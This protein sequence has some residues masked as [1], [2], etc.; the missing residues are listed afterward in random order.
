[1]GATVVGKEIYDEW[2]KINVEIHNKLEELKNLDKEKK[3]L[4]KKIETEG[5][6]DFYV[7]KMNESI[8]KYEILLEEVSELKEKSKK[9]KEKIN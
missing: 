2:L 1:M 3:D 5:L 6:N 4:I 8:S 9:L 7:K